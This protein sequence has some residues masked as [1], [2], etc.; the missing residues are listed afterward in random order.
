MLLL[1][2]LHSL[3]PPYLTNPS[4]DAQGQA[5]SSGTSIHY[6]SPEQWDEVIPASNEGWVQNL[7]KMQ[8]E[9]QCGWKGKERGR[10]LAYLYIT[11]L[12]AQGLL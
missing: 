1:S 11:L 10:R 5:M 3:F 9:D 4:Q 2:H 6:P 7:D 8:V 12:R